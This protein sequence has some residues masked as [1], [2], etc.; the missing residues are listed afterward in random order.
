MVPITSKKG[1]LVSVLMVLA[2]GTLLGTAGTAV[3]L[4][5]DE[6]S[7]TTLGVA[8]VGIGGLILILLLPLFG[9]DRKNLIKVIRRPG[10]WAMALSTAA[11]QPLFFGATTRTG[12][13]LSTVLTIGTMPLFTGLIGRTLFSERFKRMWVIATSLAVTGLVLRSWEQLESID[14]GGVVMALGA[15]FATG[16]YVNGAKYELNRGGH[17]VELPAVAYSLSAVLLLPLV[18]GDSFTWITTGAGLLTA[19]YLGAISMALANTL[20][21]VG[22]KRLSPGPTATLLLA[23]PLTATI[24]GIWILD[25]AITPLGVFGLIIVAVGLVLQG[26]TEHKT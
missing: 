14:F 2:S 21:V 4:A 3:A 9:G 23:D 19:I 25:E 11:F 18:V 5:P 24:L 16:C 17:A 1:S 20:Q 26:L 15:G 7:T 6:A 13:A 8:R 10:V 12:V 22:L